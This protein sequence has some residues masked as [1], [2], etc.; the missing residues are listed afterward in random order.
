MGQLYTYDT[1]DNDANNDDNN[2][3][4]TN[5]DCIDSLVCMPNEPK[6][7]YKIKELPVSSNKA[8]HLISPVAE[9]QN[10]SKA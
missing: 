4:W 6:K 3:K 10:I 9:S 7:L 5:H 1:N 8:I 2:T